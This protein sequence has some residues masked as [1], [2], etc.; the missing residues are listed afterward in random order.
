MTVDHI[1]ERLHRADHTST[2]LSKSGGNAAVAVDLQLEDI[3]DGI[4]RR[5]AELAQKF[6]VICCI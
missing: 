4:I 5:P 3:T 1:T 2:A 6:P